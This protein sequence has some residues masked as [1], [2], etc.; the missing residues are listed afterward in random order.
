MLW[1]I[2]TGIAGKVGSTKTIPACRLNVVG[3]EISLPAS[4]FALVAVK[5]LSKEELMQLK[6]LNNTHFPK[7]GKLLEGGNS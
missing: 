3:T 6:V 7:F 4:E 5:T 2:C 1:S